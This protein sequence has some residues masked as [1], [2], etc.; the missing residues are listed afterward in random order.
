MFDG[1]AATM[2]YEAER[3]RTAADRKWA[4]IF[5][6]LRPEAREHDA[7]VALPVVRSL[8]ML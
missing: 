1:I 4:R 3:P 8:R 2:L 5:A 7:H 6:A